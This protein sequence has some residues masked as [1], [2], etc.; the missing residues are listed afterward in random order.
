MW[1]TG[2]LLLVGRRA[3]FGYGGRTKR[4]GVTLL[5]VFTKFVCTTRPRGV[6]WPE[7]G[8]CIRRRLLGLLFQEIDD[9]SLWLFLIKFWGSLVWCSVSVPLRRSGAQKSGNDVSPSAQHTAYM[10]FHVAKNRLRSQNNAREQCAYFWAA[11]DA[12]FIR[13]MENGFGLYTAVSL[14]S[15]SRGSTRVEPSEQRLSTTSSSESESGKSQGL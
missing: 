5:G 7:P 3:P 14:S 1:L 15:L 4:R 12:A 8:T 9:S 13:A 6:K 2:T 11:R 10:R